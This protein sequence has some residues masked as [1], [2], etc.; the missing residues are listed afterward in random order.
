MLLLSYRLNELVE[1]ACKVEIR[2]F[3]LYEYR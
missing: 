2:Q 1:E 3:I